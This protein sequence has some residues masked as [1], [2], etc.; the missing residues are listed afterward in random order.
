MGMGMKK[1]PRD[2][3]CHRCGAQDAPYGYGMPGSLRDMPERYRHKRIWACADSECRAAAEARVR[4]AMG[5]R[6]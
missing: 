6:P 5:E 4:K 1:D 2:H 3:P